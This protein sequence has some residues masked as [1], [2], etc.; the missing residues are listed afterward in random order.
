MNR[1]S[2]QYAVSPWILVIA[3]WSAIFSVSCLLGITPTGKPLDTSSD[4]AAGMFLEG[5]GMALSSYFY[6]QADTYFHGGW[7]YSTL[8]VFHDSIFQRMNNEIA[9]RF[10]THISGDAAKEILPWLRLATRLNPSNVKYYLDS[11]FWL[12]H[13]LARP[14]LAEQVLREAQANNPFNY[15]IQLELGRVFLLQKKFSNAKHAFQAGLAFWPGRTDADEFEKN[16]TKARLLLYKAMLNE[17]EGNRSQAIS[18]LKEILTL[19]PQRTGIRDR[20]K[21]LEAGNEPS[22][23]ASRMM[24][25]MLRGDAEKKT[26]GLNKHRGE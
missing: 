19:F 9:P 20:I 3:T 26:G 6:R 2:S 23:L 10:H 12:A 13:E 7:E 16:D 4:S 11:A 8:E 18:S 14:D 5:S 24:S 21:E 15:Q 22:L 1:C 25:D 17:M